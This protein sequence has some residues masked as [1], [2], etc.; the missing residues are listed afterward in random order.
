MIGAAL[1]LYWMTRHRFGVGRGLRNTCRIAQSRHRS[2]LVELD[3]TY[4]PTATRAKL[5]AGIHVFQIG[6]RPYLDGVRRVLSPIS[7]REAH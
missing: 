2:R 1:S 3:Q 6:I 5:Q 7:R 4:R